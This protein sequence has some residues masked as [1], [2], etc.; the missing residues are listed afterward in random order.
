MSSPLERGWIIGLWLCLV[1]FR[2]QGHAAE[3]RAPTPPP[4]QPAAVPA[5]PF[6][7]P[8][9][10]PA[11]LLAYIER[12]TFQQPPS[13]DRETLRAFYKRLY[14]SINEAAN[15]ILAGKCTAEEIRAAA[16]WKATALLSLQRV[17]DAAAGKRREAFLAQLEKAG[18]KQ[19]AEEIRGTLLRYQLEEAMTAGPEELKTLLA[20]VKQFVGK[21]PLDRRKIGLALTTAQT[22]EMTGNQPLAADA[23]Q[24]FGKMLVAHGNKELARLGTKMEG[25][26]RRLTLPGKKMPLAG[27]FLDGSR[28]DW[29]RYQGKVVLVQFWA[30]WCGPCRI[31]IAN[32]QNN[33]AL[34]HD[35]GFE[36]LGIN[37]DDHRSEVEYFLKENPLPWKNLFSTDPRASGMDNPLAVHYGVIG[38]P[39]LILI[40]PDG[41]VVSV[42]ARGKRLGRALQKLLGPATPAPSTTP[43]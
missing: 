38:I 9:G 19:L 15:K 33:Y 6:A 2:P 3:A 16:H 26:A 13:R 27:T 7:V 21:P 28:L 31:E 43:R 8:D 11:E 41:K 4:A 5:D 24:T 39:Q 12:L 25:A 36:V 10:T 14:G 37:C 42:D 29:S 23:Y 18:L 22:F 32:V 17:G 35:R 34:Y 1:L 20:D 30:T 40:G